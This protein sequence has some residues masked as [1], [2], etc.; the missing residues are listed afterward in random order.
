[1]ITISNTFHG[2]QFLTR[3]RKLSARVAKDA[4]RF[5]CGI[6]GCTCGG[7]LGERGDDET[8]AIVEERAGGST[9]ALRIAKVFPDG[10]VHLE[11]VTP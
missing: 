11:E 2:T 3:T 5:L 4:R 10:R 1:M 6:E 9:V 7:P 8:P